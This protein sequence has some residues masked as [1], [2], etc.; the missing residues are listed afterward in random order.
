MQHFASTLG[1]GFYAIEYPGYGY[2]GGEASEK[3]I[4]AASETLLQ[5]V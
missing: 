1:L 3:A 2:A 4:Y 5:K